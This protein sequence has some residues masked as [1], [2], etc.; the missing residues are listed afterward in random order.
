MAGLKGD[1]ELIYAAPDRIYTYTDLGI[2][3]MVQGFDGDVTWIKDQNCKYLELT[4]NDRKNTITGVYL[5]GMC[6]F[7]EDCINGQVD[8]LGDTIVDNINYHVFTAY[9]QGGDSLRLF[10]NADNKR[11]EIVEEKLDEISLF[12]Y[13]SDF[14][15]VAGMEI[16]FVSQTKSSVPQLNMKA[17]TNSIKF[18]VPVDYSIF[19]MKTEKPE[20]FYFP[21]GMD[22]IIVPFEY[23]Q[24]HIYL[25]ISING[26][27][28]QYFILD[29]GAG[30][31]VI[32]REYAKKIGL[33]LEGDL[34]A[35]G[36]A[37]YGSA[38]LSEIDSL[39]LDGI[40]L[41]DQV[42][43]V[44]DF[45]GMALESPGKLGGVIGYDLL[46][47]FPVKISYYDSTMTIYNPSVFMPPKGVSGV[48]FEFIM[49]IPLVVAEYSGVSGKFLIDLGNPVGLI[50]HKSFVD[51][52]NLKKSFSDQEEMTGNLGGVG[53]LSEVYAATGDTLKIGDAEILKPPLL[54][55]K[56][57]SGVVNSD[58]INGNIGNLMLQDF[59]LLLDYSSKKIYILPINK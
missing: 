55:A 43:G 11:L 35:K 5:T 42:V 53:G 19:E 40:K 24:G 48:D 27:P 25:K 10:F 23:Y 9:P 12:N 20:D 34:P 47:R 41:Y 28:A 8:Y 44:I 22:S 36:I 29:S 58:N 1:V 39:E 51:K 38:S 13:M 16:P 52:H 45:S 7:K 59:E 14:R 26:K 3:N 18:N 31:N 50:L 17:V 2:I 56:A 57:E 30:T 54:I 32:S 33:K 6:Y 4:G 49:K 37:G 15:S 46:S 21:G